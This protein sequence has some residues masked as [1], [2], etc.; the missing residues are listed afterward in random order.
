VGGDDGSGGRGVGAS[1]DGVGSARCDA[2]VDAAER[3]SLGCERLGD[4]GYR[5]GYRRRY[6]GR[7]TSRR[8]RGVNRGDSRGDSRGNSGGDGR[9]DSGGV[10]AAGERELSRVVDL[11]ATADLESVVGLVGER[12]AG[13]P[14]E[15]TAGGTSCDSVS[16]VHMIDSSP[17]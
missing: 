11:V 2:V 13:S 1:G 16:N 4:G 9:R 6:D 5:C 15:G 10:R 7:V 17:W 3:R 12:L 14:S 8:G